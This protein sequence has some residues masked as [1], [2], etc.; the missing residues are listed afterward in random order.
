M[1]FLRAVRLDASDSFVYSEGGA[2]RDGEWL[3][4]GGYAVCDP[5]GVSDRHEA[6]IATDRSRKVSLGSQAGQAARSSTSPL[7]SGN[8]NRR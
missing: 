2:A 7:T 5:A 1:K 3:V 6:D 8:K 4:S